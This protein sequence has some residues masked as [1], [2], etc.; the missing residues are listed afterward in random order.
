MTPLLFF[1][2]HRYTMYSGIKRAVAAGLA[3][4]LLATCT[5]QAPQSAW[6]TTVKRVSTETIGY[7]GIRY[8]VGWHLSDN[9]STPEARKPIVTIHDTANFAKV[10]AYEGWTHTSS[11]SKTLG[12]L[13]YYKGDNSIPSGKVTRVIG[14]G[15]RDSNPLFT[16]R[17]PNIIVKE[18]ESAPVGDVLI[19]VSGVVLRSMRK[20]SNSLKPSQ[21]GAV[22]AIFETNGGWL[23]NTSASSTENIYRNTDYYPT[24]TFIYHTVAFVKPGSDELIADDGL[25]LRYYDLDQPN[26][27][28][29]YSGEDREGVQFQKTDKNH[30]VALANDSTIQVEDRSDGLFFGSTANDEDASFKSGIIFD[31]PAGKE[32]V[33]WRS[34]ANCGTQIGFFV[35]ENGTV[36][37][38]VRAT[39]TKK[40]DKQQASVGETLHFTAA[41]KLPTS[42]DHYPSLT[43]TDK[44]QAEI[45]YVAN[46]IKVLDGTTNITNRCTT[47][48]TNHTLNVSVDPAYLKTQTLSGQSLTVE[49]DAKVVGYPDNEYVRNMGTFKMGPWAPLDTTKTETKIDGGKI[50]L[51]KSVKF[52]HGINDIATYTLVVSSVGKGPAKDIVVTDNSLPAEFSIIDG[53]IQVEG[54]TGAK[55]TAKGSHAS[56]TIPSL[57]AGKKATISFKVACPESFNGKEV[58]NTAQATFSNPT[59]DAESPVKAS[60][61]LWINAAKLDVTKV[62]DAFE[63]H[64][65]DTA[66]YT[67]TLINTT[68]GTIARNVHIDD[69]D[70]PDCVEIDTSSITVEGVPASVEYPIDGNGQH[71]TEQRSNGEVQ[72]NVSGNGFT[73]DIPFLPYNHLVTIVYSATCTRDSNGLESFNSAIATLDNPTPEDEEVVS[74]DGVWTNNTEFTLAKTVDDYE[75]QVDDTVRYAIEFQNTAAGTVAKDVLI[76]DVT[77]PAG[78]VLQHDSIAVEGVPETVDYPLDGDGEN[79]YEQRENAYKIVP[80]GN[81]FSVAIDYLPAGAPIAI[82]Y[83]AIPT[84]DINGNEIVNTATLRC[85]NMLDDKVYSADALV[86]VNTPHLA[87]EKTVKEKRTLYQPGD[88]VTYQIHVL[89][90]KIGTYARNI[91]VEDA[92]ET[93][94]MQ[95]NRSSIMVFDGEGATIDGTSVMQTRDTANFTVQTASDLVCTQGNYMRWEQL[96]EHEQDDL[97]PLEHEKHT[98]LWIEFQAIVTDADLKGTVMKNVAKAQADNSDPVEDSEEIEMIGDPEPDTNPGEDPEPAE[99]PT[100]TVGEEPKVEEKKPQDPEPGVTSQGSPETSKS[101]TYKASNPSGSSSKASEPASP[102]VRAI[103]KTGD[104]IAAHP[105]LALAGLGLGCLV[106]ARAAQRQRQQRWKKHVLR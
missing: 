21:N 39:P 75:T 62:A 57:D 60:D 25:R 106:I 37:P 68:P 105:V 55:T 44:L 95:L 16:I 99:S 46:S 93:P 103:G 7:D 2:R 74:R 50:E 61:G 48:Y 96:E 87:I 97:N 5:L 18:G 100:P 80:D 101:S 6:A 77:L 11:E 30:M 41:Q 42:S 22:R 33:L 4:L 102:V 34:G 23:M 9:A 73:V 14:G 58:F 20:D 86:W 63:Y 84:E 38:P 85:S 28:G 76:D 29:Q 1:Q 54:A 64:V 17:Y 92:F 40:V 52:E 79:K 3:L 104:W 91:T 88:T 51:A 47:T 13:I 94:G 32:F 45:D 66:T 67:V 82:T 26:S 10:N 70:L 43:F 81:G 24:G 69:T 19:T 78:L 12:Q 71:K 83:A 35:P 98:E 89:N 49:F 72:A 36:G 31:M 56:I 8:T 59:P 15:E 53:A 65:G 27:N 90:E